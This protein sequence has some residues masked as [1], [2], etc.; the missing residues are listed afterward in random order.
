MWKPLH[1]TF[2]F[3]QCLLLSLY[4]KMREIYQMKIYHYCFQIA[5]NMRFNKYMW[6]WIE[7]IHFSYIY[8][9]LFTWVTEAFFINKSNF[10]VRVCDF[11]TEHTNKIQ[12]TRVKVTLWYSVM[13]TWGQGQH[14]G[15]N[16]ENIF[17]RASLTTKEIIEF[18]KIYNF[19]SHSWYTFHKITLVR[20]QR[21]ILYTSTT[22]PEFKT[23]LI[24][25]RN[26]QSIPQIHK[27]CTPDAIKQILS[28]RSMNI[29]Y[30]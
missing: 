30:R 2:T 16:H 27:Y 28:V 1:R 10:C 20:P 8:P 3:W 17:S 4:N 7:W 11:T 29:N 21:S 13:I 5:F 6:L 26:M 18:C 9:K 15:S 12:T 25:I 22:P 23:P 19:K 24:K 14:M